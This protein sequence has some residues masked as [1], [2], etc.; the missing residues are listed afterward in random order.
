MANPV[1]RIGTGRVYTLA[2]YLKRLSRMEIY[3]TLLLTIL[4][5]GIVADHV[6]TVKTFESTHA[7]EAR[8]NL[9]GIQRTLS[10][11]AALLAHEF[12]AT[13]SASVAGELKTT[14]AQFLENHSTLLGQD[15]HL[16]ELA[17]D[18][19]ALRSLDN[20]SLEVTT[21]ARDIILAGEGRLEYLPSAAE[22][23]VIFRQLDSVVEVLESSVAD[24][25]RGIVQM[26]WATG[27]ASLLLLAAL[28]YWHFRNA[29]FADKR[30][31]ARQILKT[32]SLFEQYDNSP[33][34][35]YRVADS[36]KL[37]RVNRAWE[38]AFGCDRDQA[39]GS[40]I[41][42]FVEPE[43]AKQL[44]ESI[45]AGTKFRLMDGMKITMRRF[46]GSPMPATVYAGDQQVDNASGEGC[47]DVIVIDKT[48]AEEARKQAAFAQ[49]AEQDSF[50][51]SPIPLFSTDEKGR[52]LRAN[53]AMMEMLEADTDE[54]L[55]EM[56]LW[57]PIAVAAKRLGRSVTSRVSSSKE[58]V[59][60]QAGRAYDVILYMRRCRVSESGALGFE[61]AFI[62]VTE[63][64]EA[65]RLVE[66]SRERFRKLYDST[67]VML[68]TADADG[69]V[70]DINEHFLKHM[71]LH[72]DS[73]SGVRF[74][75]FICNK[76]RD[77]FTEWLGATI[78]GGE[79]SVIDID[80]GESADACFASRLYMQPE[81]SRS[82]KL[83]G[84]SY[85]ILDLSEQ[86]K[87]EQER[88]VIAG[89]L[90]T[91][92]KLEAIGQLAAGIAHE[93]NTPCQYVADNLTF[94][95]QAVT[96]ILPGRD[97][98]NSANDS[99]AVPP[100]SPVDLEFYAQ[101][102]PSAID[103]S[104]DGMT[105]IKKIVRAMKDFS[106]PGGDS[107]EPVDLNQLIE[108]VTTV[109]RSEWKYIAEVSLDLDSSLAPVT[110]AGSAINQVVLNMIVNAAHALESKF[111]D[112]SLGNIGIST[113]HC[114]DHVEIRIADNGEGISADNLSSIFNPF[115]TTKEVGKGTGQGLS[116]AH[117]I[118]T[119]EHGGLLDVESVPGEGT[120]FIISLPMAE[121]EVAV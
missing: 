93:I 104:I 69:N 43:T 40:S 59:F 116:I 22:A 20:I 29:V 18:G 16:N 119:E 7:D 92:E 54:E 38:A 11:R 72:R 64:E 88:D 46:D 34:I 87:A 33:V 102:L 94:L 6:L 45:A 48:E 60:S 115:F 61:G 44:Q 86:V 47:L 3:T 95:S 65:K 68:C 21:Y 19:S 103:Q 63:L 51:Y 17:L 50:R 8:M 4:G 62:D 39:L 12:K 10:Q 80:F 107:K 98:E 57:H 109:S 35:Q 73:V 89:R 84:V 66:R 25:N 9:A 49:E 71:N 106:H 31:T 105:Q 32:Q 110:C 30:E 24:R 26:T 81:R 101:E 108:S 111:T 58:T 5:V 121:L 53:A 99:D 76:D 41:F 1:R 56:D 78:D 52:C 28:G 23:D 97:S 120:T 13:G 96:E 70:T 91:A 112:G 14:V 15:N 114:G 77:R 100:Q 82:G 42:D 37:L 55:A 2:R 67:P 118:V 90:Q 36:G 117:R 27:A 83:T 113:K 85:T 79:S 75:S 74:D